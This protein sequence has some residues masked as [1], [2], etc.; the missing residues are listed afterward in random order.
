MFGLQ[1]RFFFFE[2]HILRRLTGTMYSLTDTLVIILSGPEADYGV[3]DHGGIDRGEAGY[4]GEDHGVLHAVVAWEK[5]T[6]K[7]FGSHH[8]SQWPLSV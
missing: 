1:I 6:G 5:E 7:G 8:V 3:G 2:S 4:G